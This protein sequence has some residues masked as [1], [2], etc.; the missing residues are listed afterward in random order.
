MKKITILIALT[1]L[2]LASSCRKVVEFSGSQTDPLPVLI[3]QSE[4][5]QP[6]SLRLT[7][8][9]FFLRQAVFPVIDN[10][11]ILADL[12][13]NTD[14]A[15]FSYR[16]NGIYHSGLALRPDDTLT[17]RI[18]V[19]NQ[20]EL[21]AGCRMPALPVSS[22]FTISSEFNYQ[23]SP[24]YENP[25]DTIYIFS[26]ENLDFQ[27]TLHDPANIDNY[28]CLRAYY[29]DSNNNRRYFTLNINDN[30][31][32]EQDPTADYFGINSEN[33]YRSGQQIIFSDDRINGLDHTIKGSVD[34]ISNYVFHKK[35]KLYLEVS[36]LSRDMYLYL[37]TLNKQRQSGDILS[38]INEPVQ[39]HSNV[40]G[41][42]GIL[43]ACSRASVLFPINF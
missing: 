19:P 9:N 31:I 28:Y 36:S 25:R 34:F 5:E 22:D 4:A 16:E 43:G 21:T 30:L 15:Q 12:N 7:Y 33:D 32:F 40:N 18:I 24:S 26:N 23:S 14:V 17:L 6:I 1:T 3:C 8:S 29:L 41:G 27:F 2:V 39:I 42:I 38:I 11:T 35:D 13:G 20:G 10:A 37:V